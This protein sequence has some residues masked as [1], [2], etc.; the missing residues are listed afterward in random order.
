MLGKIQK[1]LGQ[2]TA[3]LESGLPN[4][5][6]P[7]AEQGGKALLGAAHAL[8]QVVG[9]GKGGFHRFVTAVTSGLLQ[10]AAQPQSNGQLRLVAIPAFGQRRK[11]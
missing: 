8:R 6:P 2:I 7:L 3:D 10:G 1:L 5:V 9:P 4:M 11:K